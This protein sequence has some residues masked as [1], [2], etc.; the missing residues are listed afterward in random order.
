MSEIIVETVYFEEPGPQNTDRALSLA[1]DRA[2]ALGINTLVIATTSGAAAV[3]ATE[4]LPNFKIVAVTH[5][6][7][8]RESGVQELTDV[9]RSTLEQAGVQILTCQHAFGGVNRAIRKKLGTYQVDEV[10]AYTLRLFGQGM[11]V[12]AEITL[13]AADAGLVEPGEP[14]VVAAGTGHGTDTVVVLGPTNAQ[15]F[16]DLEFMEIVCLPS[17]RHPAHIS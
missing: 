4:I 5:S 6:T 8:F 16:F 12:V 2:K 3:R 10:I 9:H 17:P 7:G 14:V 1:R 13:M 15:T 11:K